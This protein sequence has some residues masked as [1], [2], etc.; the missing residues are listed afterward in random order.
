MPPTGPSPVLR[1]RR[2][3]LELRKLREA[4]GL[5]GDQVIARVGWASA[6]KLSRLENGRSRPDPADVAALLD[7]FGVTEAQRG[8]L[9]GIT[10][11]AGDMR[12]WLRKYSVMT[13]QQRSFAELEAGCA[14]ILE[15]NPVLVPGLLQTIG[16]AR[17]RIV[18][19]RQIESWAGE[20]EHGGT[21]E[22]EVAA[23]VARQSLLS[24]PDA[25]RYTAVLEESA[26]GRRAGPPEVLREQ[27]AQLCDL[28]MLPHVTLH[29]LLRDT[30]IGN[31]YLPPTA[32]SIY[33]FADPLDPET[34]AIEGGFTNAMSTEVNTLNAYKV[35]F[36]WLRSAALS[37]T[38]T[39][40]WLFEAAGRL[41]EA[42]GP[43]T[44]AHGSATAPA[45][46]R[47]HSDRLTDR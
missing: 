29:V 14:E 31:W 45:Q 40:S 11:E 20:S 34:L 10:G 4:A 30:P 7:L 42:A 39:T 26:L 2:L 3:G 41:A 5:T 28:A 46:R 13:P 19:A 22:D 47:R 24:H 32:F 21:P 25:P 16:Y 23:R 35:A 38:D 15:Y 8:E 6:S 37:A 44:A 17:L 1:R 36:E 27:L 43:S 12:G 33:R 9:L 18:S